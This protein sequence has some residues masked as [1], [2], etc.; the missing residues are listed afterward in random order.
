MGKLMFLCEQANQNRMT[1]FSLGDR[2]RDWRSSEICLYMTYFAPLA[3]PANLLGGRLG[4]GGALAFGSLAFF[5]AS[6]AF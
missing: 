5:S 6:P 1:A 3:T 2:R 4:A